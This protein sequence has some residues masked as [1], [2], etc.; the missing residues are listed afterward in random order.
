MNK[1]KAA[2]SGQTPQGAAAKLFGGSPLETVRWTD[3]PS[4]ALGVDDA[5]HT[6]ADPPCIPHLLSGITGECGPWPG[7][8][9]GSL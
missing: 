2:A 5:A 7:N 3:S 9:P 4:N 1:A 6:L 8:P